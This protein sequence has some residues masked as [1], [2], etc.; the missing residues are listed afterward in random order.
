MDLIPAS[1]IGK[2]G[3]VYL[4]KSCPRH[5]EFSILL[6]ENIEEYRELDNFYFSQV[7][8][9]IPPQE[10]Y[11]HAT[12][13]CNI[14]C[15]IC[16]LNFNNNAVEL[17]LEEL[18]SLCSF[19][20]VQRLT[21]SHSEATVCNSFLDMVRILRSKRK[22]INIHTNGIKLADYNFASALKSAGINQVSLQFDGFNE[23][24]YEKI[25]GARLLEQKMK[26]LDNLK[27]LS[28][29]VTLNITVARGINENEIGR[30]FDYAIK[31]IFIKDISFITYSNYSHDRMGMDRYI[32]PDELLKYMELH[33]GGRVSRKNII[34]F[35]KIFYAYISIFKIRKCFYYYHFMAART[36]R[37]YWTVDEFIDLPKINTVL[38][39][40]KNNGRKMSR[41]SFS[42][43]ICSAIKI[44]G[45]FLLPS[46]V[47]MLLKRGFP[48][49]PSPFMVITFATICDPY[50]YDAQ[51]AQNCGQG[52]FGLDGSHES[53]GTFLMQYI[54]N[55]HENSLCQ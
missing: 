3:S 4:E 10:Y 22:V 36:R 38:E 15:P 42:L 51:I 49:K 17:S 7:P 27:R 16:F 13:R 9:H 40:V 14:A 26:A 52:I 31:E 34:L 41:F 5:K 24:V 54:K 2:N 33:T 55:K 53:Y 25:R 48:N 1:V 18:N 8:Q 28:I 29:P 11:L 37:G 21:F 30:I 12:N 45:L 50:K 44:K 19:K 6:S 47:L 39:K 23:A 32:M 43:L 20:D 46:G 35:Q